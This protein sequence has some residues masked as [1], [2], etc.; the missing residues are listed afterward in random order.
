MGEGRRRI[1][2]RWNEERL[3]DEDDDLRQAREH[4]ALAGILARVT[5]VVGDAEACGARAR[6]GRMAFAKGWRAE[7]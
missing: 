6:G 2:R 5:A 7:G 4:R 3:D 1:T